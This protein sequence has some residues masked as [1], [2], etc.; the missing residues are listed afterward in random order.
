MGLVLAEIILILIACA[1]SNE[2][3]SYR[4]PLT[5]RFL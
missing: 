3:G 1:R 2:G 4:Y 5:L